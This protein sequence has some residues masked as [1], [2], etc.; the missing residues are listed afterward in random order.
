MTRVIGDANGRR[1]LRRADSFA[2]SRPEFSLPAPSP[3]A[4]PS[5][6]QTLNN[7]LNS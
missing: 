3:S 1:L 2:F 6:L 5:V 7:Q 4:F